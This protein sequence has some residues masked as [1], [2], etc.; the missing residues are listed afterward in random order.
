M[1]RD[2]PRAHGEIMLCDFRERNHL[3]LALGR[4][5]SRDGRPRLAIVAGWHRFMLPSVLNHELAVIE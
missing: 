5:T 3:D 4:V 1:K 2:H